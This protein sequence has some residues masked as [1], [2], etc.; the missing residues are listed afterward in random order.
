[1][2]TT[3]KIAKND[4]KLKYAIRHRNRCRRCGRPRGR[5][6]SRST[7]ADDAK[8]AVGERL[9]GANGTEKLQGCG[10]FRMERGN[11]HGQTEQGQSRDEPQK[12]H[13]LTSH[14]Y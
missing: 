7:V 2:A 5:V 6:V 14:G 9:I 10:D 11:V 3:A 8:V 13:M 12:A 1:M 4:G